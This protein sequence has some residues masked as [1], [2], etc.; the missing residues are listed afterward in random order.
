[1]NALNSLCRGFL[2][3]EVLPAQASRYKND[4]DDV[5]KGSGI[6][7]HQTPRGKCNAQS[8]VD[9]PEYVAVEGGRHSEYAQQRR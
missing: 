9:I 4:P 8:G 3:S 5:C 6:Y 7:H 2:L 1:M